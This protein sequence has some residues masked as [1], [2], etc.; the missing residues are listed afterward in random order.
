M[1]NTLYGRCLF[2]ARAGRPA[3]R[4]NLRCLGYSA[5][6]AIAVAGCTI[7]PDYRDEFRNCLQNATGSFTH[8]D[9]AVVRECREYA[10]EATTMKAVAK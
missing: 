10:R 9:A 4:A 2:E 6:I 3:A 8:A 7:Q 1:H 5:T